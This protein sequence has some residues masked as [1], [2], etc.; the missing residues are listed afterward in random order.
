MLHEK[1][2]YEL[3]GIWLLLSF[4]L[5]MHA[6]FSAEIHN[7]KDIGVPCPWK[8]EEMNVLELQ[9]KEEGTIF[10]VYKTYS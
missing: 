9:I 3:V 6:I 8:R 1:V 7:L 5:P 2:Q 10:Q 4:I